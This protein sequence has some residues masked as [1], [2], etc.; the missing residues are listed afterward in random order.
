[1]AP[2]GSGQLLRGS[3]R[4][5]SGSNLVRAGVHAH[6][7]ASTHSLGWLREDGRKAHSRHGQK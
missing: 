2:A 3:V 5:L 1:M 7:R 4:K 6:A